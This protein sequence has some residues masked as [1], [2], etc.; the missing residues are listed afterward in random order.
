MRL[1]QNRVSIS[2][3]SILAVL[4]TP[5]IAAGQTPTIDHQIVDCS[6]ARNP[7]NPESKIISGGVLNGKAVYLAKPEFPAAA[8]AVGARGSVQVS[9]LIDE[10][11]SISPVGRGYP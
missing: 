11:G 10:S 7:T 9:V 5:L 1:N 4:V 6:A 2:L 3:F 8:Y